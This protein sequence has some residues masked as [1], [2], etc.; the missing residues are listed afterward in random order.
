MSE[1]EINVIRGGIGVDPDEF[2]EKVN[3]C[4]KCSKCDKCTICF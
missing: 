1:D 3:K 4:D 2:G